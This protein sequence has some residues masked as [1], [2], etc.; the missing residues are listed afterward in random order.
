[1]QLPW[2]TTPSRYELVNEWLSNIRRNNEGMALQ[3]E[4]ELIM[5]W[6]NKIGECT[7]S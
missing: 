6:F 3:T 1:M 2:Y 7:N 4:G 5:M